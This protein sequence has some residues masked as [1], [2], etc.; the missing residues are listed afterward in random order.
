MCIRFAEML[1]MMKYSGLPENKFQSQEIFGR[2]EDLDAY[3]RLNEIK[4]NIKSYVQNGH[5][6]YIYSKSTGN[7]KTTWAI[8]LLQSYFNAVWAGNGLRLRGFFIPTQAFLLDRK[9]FNQNSNNEDYKL[10]SITDE[11]GN[12]LLTNKNLIH[13]DLIVW[14]D[15]IVK[16]FTDYDYIQLFSI[17]DQRI[18]LGKSNIFTCGSDMEQLEK[19]CGARVASRLQSN[20]DLIEFKCDDI[21]AL[22]GDNK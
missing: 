3:T 14:D 7:G 6:L 19:L 11:F 15:F 13:I 17:I 12:N 8:K 1:T 4:Q 2:E 18:L 16:A 21:R 5:N 10:F 20:C 22:G 9:N